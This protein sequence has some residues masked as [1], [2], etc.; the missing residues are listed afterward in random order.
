MTSVQIGLEACLAAPPEILR[1]K[2]LGLLMNQASIDCCFRYAHHLF[3]ECFPGR[4]KAIF[5]PQHGLWGEQQDNMIESAHRT[6]RRLGVPIYSLYSETRRPTPEMLEGL[7]CLVVDLQDVGTRVYTFIWTVSY[8]LESCAAAG[9][10]VVVLDRPNPLGGELVEGPRLDPAFASFVG[11]A[12]I[13]MRHALTMAEMAAYLNEYFKL[14]AELHVVPLRGW[15]RAM[16]F[17]ET[18]RPWVLPSPNLPRIEGVDVYPGQVLLEGTNLSEGRGTTVPFEVCGAP[19]VDPERLI[20]ALN[21][22]DLPGLSLR[23]IR[24]EPT[25]QKWKGQSC[26]GIWLHVTDRRAFRPY[27]TTVAIL[28]SVRRLWPDEFAWRSPPY[29]YETEKP[30]IDILAGGVAL[31]EAVDAALIKTNA[32]LPELTEADQDAWWAE[33]APYLLYR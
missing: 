30:P 20:D 15:R 9:V 2:R 32:D 17:S 11:R 19:Y 13:P 12:A 4:L 33:V 22:F 18:A 7:D 8:C 27:R 23:P 25:F 28:G 5:S 6:E 3:A 29:E 10:P 21:S 31:R 24:F 16:T 1:G 14:G 26:G